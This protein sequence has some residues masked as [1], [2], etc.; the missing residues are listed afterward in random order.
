MDST[1]AELE[2]FRQKWREEVSKKAKGKAPSTAAPARATQASSSRTPATKSNA[3]EISAHARHQ[4]VEEIDEVEPHTYHDLEE[5]QH[6]RRLDETAPP[7]AAKEPSSAL[8]HYEKAVEKESQGS[9]GDSVNL[10][11]KAFR[12]GTAI[13][14]EISCILTMSSSTQTSIRPTRTNISRHHHSR[15]KHRN[16]RIPTLQMHPSRYPI[17]PTTPYMVV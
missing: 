5:K 16:L 13:F 10:Y 15:R 3:P 8:E 12:V 7:A 4:S 2:N 9:L 11:R 1:E 14:A 6:G 17:P